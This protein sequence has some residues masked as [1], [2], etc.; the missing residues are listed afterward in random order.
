MSWLP[1]EGPSPSASL[2]IVLLHR[3]L[4]GGGR[5][6]REGGVGREGGGAPA[7][8]GSLLGAQQWHQEVQE[9]LSGPQGLGCSS[10]QHSVGGLVLPTVQPGKWPVLLE[11]ESRKISS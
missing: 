1:W 5:R 9:K 8:G 3:A 7:G 11:T 10:V 6:G 4:H 2:Y